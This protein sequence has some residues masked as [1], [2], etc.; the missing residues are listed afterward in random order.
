MVARWRP[1]D[2]QEPG[3]AQHLR[4]LGATLSTRKASWPPKCTLK[5]DPSKALEPEGVVAMV[6]RQEDRGR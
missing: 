5:G 1:V 3:A 4:R 6:G 2:G